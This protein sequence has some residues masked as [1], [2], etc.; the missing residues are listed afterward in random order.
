MDKYKFSNYREIIY[1]MRDLKAK[2]VFNFSRSRLFSQ[3]A[4]SRRFLELKKMSHEQELFDV[5]ERHF[6]K[7]QVIQELLRGALMSMNKYAFRY[8]QVCF[9]RFVVGTKKPV[10]A[11][12]SKKKKKALTTLMN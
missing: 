8:K 11:S 1:F 4:R 12:L 2:N 9:K 10:Y 7:N 6:E 3:I 5:D